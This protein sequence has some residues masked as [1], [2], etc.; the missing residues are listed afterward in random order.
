MNRST[1]GL[2]VHHQLLEFTQT[3]VHPVGDAVQTSQLHLNI[4]ITINNCN[5]MSQVQKFCKVRKWE[6]NYF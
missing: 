5:G 2:P 3:Y 4:S 1:Q 6:Q